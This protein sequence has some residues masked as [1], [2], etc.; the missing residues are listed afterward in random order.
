MGITW[1]DKTGTLFLY[2]HSQE[3]AIAQV[4]GAIYFSSDSD[5]LEALGFKAKELKENKLY[6]IR[7]GKIVKAHKIPSPP[8]VAVTYSGLFP[9]DTIGKAYSADESANM[10][11]RYF[12]MV[13]GE[14]GIYADLPPEIMEAE[15]QEAL[16]SQMA[17]GPED[18]SSDPTQRPKGR[19]TVLADSDFCLICHA[20]ISFCMCEG[21]CD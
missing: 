1:I 4:K 6:V 11:D 3:L 19:P 13:Y 2:R 10:R 9:G 16:E 7:D 12:N 15:R 8:E 20:R 5:H 18:P 17:N 14:K 21:T